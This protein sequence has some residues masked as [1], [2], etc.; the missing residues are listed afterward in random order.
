MSGHVEDA[1]V[2]K[3]LSE[4]RK[5]CRFFKVLGSYPAEKQ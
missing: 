3:A 1:N 5:E 2:K 4:L